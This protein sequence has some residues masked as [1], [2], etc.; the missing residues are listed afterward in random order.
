MSYQVNYYTLALMQDQSV[1]NIAQTT[2]VMFT[3]TDIEKIPELLNSH[4][5]NKKLTSVITKIEYIKGKC[6]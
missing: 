6:I 5:A 1:G 2:G 4:L 3:D